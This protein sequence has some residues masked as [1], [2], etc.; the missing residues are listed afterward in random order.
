MANTW[1]Q[2]KQFRIE[3]DQTAMKVGTD[4]VLLGAWAALPEG[5]ADIKVL[6]VGTGTG[7]IALMA[8]QRTQGR[9]EAIEVNGKAAQQAAA[10]CRASPWAE[11]ISV[12]HA[13]FRHASFLEPTSYDHVLSNPPYFQDQLTAPDPDRSL[14]RHAQTLSLHDL[15]QR[16]RELL[17]PSGRIS[18]ILPASRFS[19][20]LRIFAARGF[21]PARKLTIVHP[22]TRK[23]IRILAEWRLES[24]EM[25]EAAWSVHQDTGKGWS[26]EY[27]RLTRAFYPGF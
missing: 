23:P 13:D 16:A 10:N 14:A 11:R 4:G 1:F 20:A 9:I 21:S 19:E 7:L 24:A 2:F 6:D 3:Q 12:Y 27:M 25:E 22:K 5:R 26:D 15:C 8:A 17:L 18:L